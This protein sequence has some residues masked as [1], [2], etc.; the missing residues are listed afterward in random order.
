MRGNSEFTC[1]SSCIVSRK[2][3]EKGGVERSG[4]V[5]TVGHLSEVVDRQLSLNPF[6]TQCRAERLI[7]LSDNRPEKERK[8][9]LYRCRIRCNNISPPHFEWYEEILEMFFFFSNEW[10]ISR[11]ERVFQEEYLSLFLDYF[12]ISF[13][14]HNDKRDNLYE[15]RMSLNATTQFSVR[16][17][18]SIP[19]HLFRIAIIHVPTSCPRMLRL[20]WY[21]NEMKPR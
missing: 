5:S 17:L 10:I 21:S 11:Y 19:F 9:S 20:L 7:P 8:H 2:S 14:R 4:S 6:S 18:D 3:V 12:L 1:C 16:F 15:I 13:F